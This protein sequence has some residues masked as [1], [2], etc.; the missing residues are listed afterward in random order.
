M[1]FLE[2]EMNASLC[3]IKL[4]SHYL[5]FP[6]FNL[7]LLEAFINTVEFSFYLTHSKVR[8]RVASP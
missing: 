3:L 1:N 2:V 6:G 5:T 8:E 7:F 4:M